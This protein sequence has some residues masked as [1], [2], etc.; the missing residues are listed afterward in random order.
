[1]YLGICIWVPYADLA[2]PQEWSVERIKRMQD[3]MQQVCHLGTILIEWKKI[4]NT[5]SKS[6]KHYQPKTFNKFQQIPLKRGAPPHTD[7]SKWKWRVV[8][9]LAEKLLPAVAS[10]R[11]DQLESITIRYIT[12][13]RYTH[14]NNNG[15]SLAMVP[16]AAGNDALA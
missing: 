10:A 3:W 9:S 15:H 13:R 6:P 11:G 2:Q 8:V 14:Y 7:L 4:Q 1:M 5:Q 16:P 12:T